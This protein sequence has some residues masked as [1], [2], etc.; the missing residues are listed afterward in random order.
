MPRLASLTAR[1]LAGQ[2]AAPRILSLEHTLD[3]PITTSP[4]ADDNFFGFSV[5]ISGNYAI[6]G[7]YST[8]SD[9][10]GPGEGKAYIYNASTGALIHTLDNPNALDAGFD[11][12]A[13]S[14]GISGNYAIVGAF[15]EDDSNLNSGKAYIFNVTTGA[16]VHTLDNPNAFGTSTGDNFGYSVAIDGDRA[17]VG[18][19]FEDDTDGGNSGKA[20][21]FNVTTGAL[22]HTLDNPNAFNT[23]AADNFGSSV[24]ISG[25]YA[26]VGAPAEDDADGVQSGKAY[27]FNVTNGSLLH[28]LDNPNPVGISFNDSFGGSVAISGNY[29][30]VGARLEDEA[31]V[32][33]DSGK[34][35]IFDVTTG[36]LVH[37]LDNPNAVGS[38]S[39]DQFGCSV[40]ISGGY[41][42]VGA[43]Q[44][45]DVGGGGLDYQGKAYIFSVGSGNLVHTLDN[46]NAVISRSAQND[47]FGDAVA[48]GPIFAIVGAKQEDNASKNFNDAGK[49]YIFKY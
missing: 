24:A 38:P 16:L 14:V 33:N 30:I 37:T 46:P 18:A 5:A 20:Y 1:Q 11:W 19:R 31:D 27:I 6:V 15:E 23:S 34:A 2:G 12:F 10:G 29:A 17:I 7:A 45:L 9:N 39:S 22:V 47:R 3:N 49:A 36:N 8:P 35:Y 26:I 44:E 43:E 48:I 42:I 13:S 41:A 21:I 28:T 32:G 4:D 40:A 25:N